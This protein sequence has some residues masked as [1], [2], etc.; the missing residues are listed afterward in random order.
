MS[1]LLE[2]GRLRAVVP[3]LIGEHSFAD[4]ATGGGG[5]GGG[6]GGHG[7]GGGAP[8]GPLFGSRAYAGLSGAAHSRVNA[9]AAEVLAALGVEPT[10]RLPART[11]REVVEVVLR[12]LGIAAHEYF[13][14]PDP[15]AAGAS[16]GAPGAGLARAGRQHGWEAGMR[17]L[18]AA[19]RKRLM[20][21]LEAALQR[22]GW[23]DVPAG[24]PAPAAS[25][26]PPAAELRA[27]GDG[28][29]SPEAP[30]PP[31]SSRASAAQ[32]QGAAQE[33]AGGAP[34]VALFGAAAP[35]LAAADPSPLRGVAPSPPATAGAV[36][37]G[38]PG[39]LVTDGW[40]EVELAR[41]RAE[42]EAERA[43]TLQARLEAERAGLEAERA[44]TLARAEADRAL[45]ALARAEA[46]AERGKAA[47]GEQAPAQT[48]CCCV[49]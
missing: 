23:A 5:G 24:S 43:R 19:A 10:P 29:A 45:A 27:V 48:A 16:A 32:E 40:A 9:R 47:G 46:G 11:V 49:C 22:E 28:L 36:Q 12:H 13:P 25:R 1:E 38:P 20:T 15:G 37:G 35:P 34:P 21:V 3:I 18:V 14:G 30:G 26:A 42:L 17:A 39:P 4:A 8:M 2:A 7:G 31:P 44:L 33:Q 6:G 41:L